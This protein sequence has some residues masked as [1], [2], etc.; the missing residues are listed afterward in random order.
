MLNVILNK[1]KNL[2]RGDD[3]FAIATTILVWPLMLL[4]VSGIFVTGETL[5]SKLILQNAADAAAHAGAMAQA[6]TLSRIAVI[7]RMMAWTYIQANKMEMDYTVVNW[8]LLADTVMQ[9]LKTPL[10]NANKNA[11]LTCPDPVHKS[12][13]TSGSA[14]QWGWYTGNG[15]SSDLV[16]SPGQISLNGHET[17]FN[18]ARRENLNSLRTAL[19]ASLDTAFNNINSM[20]GARA[21]LVKNCAERVETSLTEVFAANASEFSTKASFWYR[22]DKTSSYLTPMTDENAFL[23]LAG[24]AQSASLSTTPGIDW[25]RPDN[26]SADGFRRAYSGDSFTGVGLEARFD[27]GFKGW[28]SSGTPAVCSN[29]ITRD[30][31]VSVY[32]NGV[33]TS[34]GITDAGAYADGLTAAAITGKSR[35]F[36]GYNAN[37]RALPRQVAPGFLTSGAVLVGAKL[38]QV[39]PLAAIFGD[40]TGSWFDAHTQ[41]DSTDYW[42][43]SAARA[44]AKNGAGYSRSSIA[45]YSPGNTEYTAVMLPAAMAGNSAGDVAKEVYDG[46]KPNGWAN[47]ADWSLLNNFASRGQ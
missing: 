25:W 5:R 20:N 3:G 42:C 22:R 39:N 24:E 40:L 4:A 16:Y 41:V 15:H 21:D 11:S 9:E 34:D 23:A 33:V 47:L 13:R 44:C 46:L 43:L 1:F 19:D 45:S 35:F 26:S 28:Q 32:G 14:G 37:V 17:D 36:L 2:G 6:D 12:E 8:A 30:T 29:Y 27:I 10:S 18:T 7:N 38:P 31:T